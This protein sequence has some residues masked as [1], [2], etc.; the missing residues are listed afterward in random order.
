LAQW[1]IALSKL[2]DPRFPP[3][4]LKLANLIVWRQ[5]FLLPDTRLLSPET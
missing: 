2:R 5:T 3:N 4:C 1:A